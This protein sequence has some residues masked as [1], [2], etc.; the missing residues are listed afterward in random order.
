MPSFYFG[1]GETHLLGS[2][3][4]VCGGFFKFFYL[5]YHFLEHLGTDCICSIANIHTA[6]KDREM[7]EIIIHKVEITE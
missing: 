5:Y 1:I 3:L 7:K 2:D 6:V 4:G